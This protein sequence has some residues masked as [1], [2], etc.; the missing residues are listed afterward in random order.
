MSMCSVV[1]SFGLIMEDLLSNATG[2]FVSVVVVRP[3]AELY[4]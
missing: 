4:V 2:V 3:T 1:M